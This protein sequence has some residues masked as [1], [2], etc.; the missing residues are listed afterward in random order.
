MIKLIK[1]IMIIP[2][3]YSTGK[4][5]KNFAKLMS[6]SSAVAS[7]NLC[8]CLY[9]KHTELSLGNWQK[10]HSIWISWVYA[11]VCLFVRTSLWSDQAREEG[12]EMELA[13]DVDRAKYARP[14]N[15]EEKIRT[16][17]RVNMQQERKKGRRFSL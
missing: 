5:M 14:R 6:R 15:L 9:S 4:E 16:G 10:D 1:A 2:S 3:R 13:G 8:L 17:S 12:L 11:N 7:P